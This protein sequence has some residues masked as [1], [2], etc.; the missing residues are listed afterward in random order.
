MTEREKALEA[1][2]KAWKAAGSDEEYYQAVQLRNAALAMPATV[3]R[4]PNQK[5][6]SF[7]NMSDQDRH[8]L[9]DMLEAEFARPPE[10]NE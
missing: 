1:A 10:D 9:A 6:G 3:E 7:T 5:V 2:L 4:R 8:E